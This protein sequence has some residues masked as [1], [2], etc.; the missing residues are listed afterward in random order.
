MACFLSLC[1]I[2]AVSINWPLAFLSP[3]L[4]SSLL[5]S[6]KKPLD[7]KAGLGLVTLIFLA[8][9]PFVLLGLIVPRWPGISALLL[10]LCF[11]YIFYWR[12]MEKLPELASLLLLIGICLMPLMS[13]TSQALPLGVTA[14]FIFSAGIAV[15]FAWFAF[16]V[17]PDPAGTE[18][19]VTASSSTSLFRHEAQVKAMASTLALLPLALSF[20]ALD[21]LDAALVFAFVAIL[22]QNPDIG[23]NLKAGVGLLL[24][25]FLGGCI[26]Y[27]V[28]ILVK[29]SPELL[30]FY[31]LMLLCLLLLGQRIFSTHR[32]SGLYSASLS[33]VLILLASVTSS[34]GGDF[35]DKFVSRMVQIFCAGA[36][37]IIALVVIKGLFRKKALRYLARF[38]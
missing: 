8:L 32:L 17:F 31:C 20:Y 34:A 36:Y 33:T 18:Y 7:L 28:F 23:T 24:G 35:Q 15:V 29:A 11:Y 14:G 27:A 12:A 13:L 2:V 37:V 6:N 4:L 9:F 26:A 1:F 25:N 30:F 22:M 3:V 10:I 38:D 16:S 19:D 5:V 21:L